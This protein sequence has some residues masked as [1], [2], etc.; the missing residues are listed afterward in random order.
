MCAGGTTE[1]RYT[2]PAHSWSTASTPFQRT[3]FSGSTRNSQTVSGLA[4]IR[5]SRVTASRSV[6]LSTLLPLLSFRFALERLEPLVPEAL[7]ERLHV[8][9]TLGPDAVEAARSVS[10]FVHEPGLLEHGQVLRDRRPRH[11]EVRGDLAGRQLLV[12]HELQDPAS[13]RLGEGF[14]GGL[15]RHP[16]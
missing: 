9:E 13:V 3:I 4:S 15:H 16:L 2:P 7:E 5:S 8:G 10:S 14:Q 6:V 11:L 12:P 1:T